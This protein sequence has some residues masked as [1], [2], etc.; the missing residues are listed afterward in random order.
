[1]IKAFEILGIAARIF[2][3]VGV[4]FCFASTQSTGQAIL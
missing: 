4:E 3:V 2:G 1:M